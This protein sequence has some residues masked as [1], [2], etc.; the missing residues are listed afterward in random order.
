MKKSKPIIFILSLFFCTRIMLAQKTNIIGNAPYLPN[1]AL[2]FYDYDDYLTLTPIKKQDI[3][4]D[5]NGKFS[6]S[7]NNTSTSLVFLKYKNVKVSFYCEPGKTYRLRILKLDSVA[8]QNLAAD[9]EAEAIFQNYD[10]LE[11]N[12]LIRKYNNYLVN[13]YLD[14]GKLIVVKA[15]KV[16]YKKIEDFKKQTLIDFAYANNSYFKSYIKSSFSALDEIVFTPKATIYKEYYSGILKYHDYDYIQSISAHFND[17]IEQLGLTKNGTSVFDDINVRHNY[18]ALKKSISKADSIVTNDTLRELLIIKGLGEIYYKVSTKKHSVELV[19]EQIIKQTLSQQNKTIAHN[20]L[21]RL[22]Y[23]QINSKA[24]N[25]E[26]ID[27]TGTALKLS[28]LKGKMVYLNFWSAN[29]ISSMEELLA[30][31]KLN[32]KYNTNI[33]FVS[34]CSDE[35]CDAAK[36]FVKKNKLSWNL[37]YDK[38]KK[39][40]NIYTVKVVPVFFLIDKD[41]FLIKSPAESPSQNIEDT[42]RDMSQKKEKKG[43]V[44]EKD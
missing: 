35:D 26:A 38:D 29:S 44:G 7:F 15:I 30:I 4:I 33:Y 17:Y 42:F 24:P 23:L 25:F 22:T 5:V 16:L 20:T 28:N 3:A 13:F 2:E 32:D 6:F 11:L 43:K 19:L 1:Q 31:K 41:G 8:N 9:I 18:D 10:S 14:N 34:V 27:A 36:F 37:L 21:S 12:Q 40:A 39:I